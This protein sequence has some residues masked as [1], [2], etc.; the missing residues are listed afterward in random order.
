MA[1]AFGAFGKVPA[2]GDFLR[3]G[4]PP[5]FTDVWDR[6]L[7]QT[8]LASETALG[9][10][11]R[12]CYL[13]APLWRFTLAAGLSGASGAIGIV[14]ASVDRVGRL[15][16]L[17]LAALTPPA[18]PVVPL[19]LEA[20]PLFEKLETIA[21]ET[22]DGGIGSAHLKESLLGLTVEPPAMAVVATVPGR[23]LLDVAGGCG[24]A[25]LAGALLRGF[26]RPALW[27]AHL[28]GRTRLMIRE[29]MPTS[30]DA[31]LLFDMDAPDWQRAE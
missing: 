31:V 10:R 7:Q 9:P 15:Y 18:W 30:Q 24:T 22:L 28:S 6:W 5:S 27:S 19:H 25:S 17:T 14:M 16:P 3:L 13:S 4:L 8:M 21:L 2:L 23:L 12:D 1:L 11:W 26:E 20:K 29:G